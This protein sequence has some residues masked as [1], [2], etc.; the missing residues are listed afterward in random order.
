M[1][2]VS[3]FESYCVWRSRGYSNCLATGELFKLD[4]L[5]LPVSV[6]QIVDY[7]CV[8]SARS[9]N[10]LFSFSSGALYAAARFAVGSADR[11]LAV[12]FPQCGIPYTAIY[13]QPR[14]KL[15]D[16]SVV[17]MP[18]QACQVRPT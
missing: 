3:K 1:L 13:C 16:I 4:G 18:Y 2:F 17:S 6:S 15:T 5:L 8:C 7:C 14:D 10:E 11:L 9:W 12:F